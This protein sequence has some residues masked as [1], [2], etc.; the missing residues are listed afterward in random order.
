MITRQP[1]DEKRFTVAWP[2]P[3]EAPVTFYWGVCAM[4]GNRA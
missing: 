4:V 3:R 1:G 2:M